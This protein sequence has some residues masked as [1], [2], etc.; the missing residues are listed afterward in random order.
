MEKEEN[1]QLGSW[2]DNRVAPDFISRD[3]LACP[4]QCPVP[5]PEDSP[6]MSPGSELNEIWRVFAAID[7][8]A[9][10]PMR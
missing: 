5:R 7:R 9:T 4:S 1:H 3:P 10:E 8:L 2:I 6:A